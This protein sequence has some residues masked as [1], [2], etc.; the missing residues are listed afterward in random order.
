[1]SEQD[2]TVL[3]TGGTGMVGSAIKRAVTDRVL[4][5]RLIAPSRRECDL[6]QPDQVAQLFAAE[7][8]DVVLHCAAKVGGI[9]AN[10]DDPCGFLTDNLHINLNVIEAAATAGIPKMINIGSSCMYPKDLDRPLRETDLLTAPLEP[11]NE[12]Y[13]LAKLTASK[14]C[15][16]LGRAK[17]LHYKTLIPCN[18]FGPGDNFTGVGS[19]LIAAAIFKIHHAVHEGHSDVTIWGSG[20]ARREFLYVDDLAGFIVESVTQ[21]DRLPPY[22]NLGYGDDHSVNDYYRMV[23]DALEFQGCF[24]HDLDKPEGMRRKL[25]DSQAATAYNWK[26]LTSLSDGIDLTVINFLESR[27]Q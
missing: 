15:E 25:M 24:I 11:T 9:Q 14:L 5:W 22:L 3:L 12:G 8:F 21:L 26:P 19:H 6:G 17:G 27:L 1:M 23:A 7:S 20:E 16:Y 18:L 10:I 2:L 13:A 4:P